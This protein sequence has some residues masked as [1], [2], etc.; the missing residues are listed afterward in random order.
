MSLNFLFA[1]ILY[2]PQWYL[3]PLHTCGCPYLPYSPLASPSTTLLPD[4]IQLL[5]II[6]ILACSWSTLLLVPYLLYPLPDLCMLSSCW[7]NSEDCD[8]ALARS[9]SPSPPS[10][11][12]LQTSW[13]W[14]PATEVCLSY[15]LGGSTCV[16]NQ[17]TIVWTSLLPQPLPLK[18]DPRPWH[19]ASVSFCISYAAFW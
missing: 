14:D 8:L 15:L 2:F 16:F 3:A 13:C 11:A 12:L 5:L 9:E 1:R 7:G 10:G 18:P 17:L 19:I 6:E 4:P